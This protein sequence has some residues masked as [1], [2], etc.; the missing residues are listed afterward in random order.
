MFMLQLSGMI[1]VT[2]I[3]VFVLADTMGEGLNLFC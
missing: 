2:M 3:T 1:P